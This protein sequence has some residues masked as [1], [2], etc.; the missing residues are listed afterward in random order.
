MTISCE[1]FTRFMEVI[2]SLVR[3]GLTFHANADTFKITLLG[4]F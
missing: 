4:G 3:D 2:S 1:N